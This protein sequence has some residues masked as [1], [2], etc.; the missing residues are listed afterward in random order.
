MPRVR[1][2]EHLDPAHMVLLAET[3]VDTFGC[4]AMRYSDTGAWGFRVAAGFGAAF[5]RSAADGVRQPDCGGEG[6]PRGIH[7]AR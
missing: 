3:T 1:G 2:A 6:R 4:T 7:L 5:E